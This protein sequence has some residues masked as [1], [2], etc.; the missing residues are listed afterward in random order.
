[1]AKV[2]RI[3]LAVSVLVIALAAPTSA[4]RAGDSATR[5]GRLE[6]APAARESLAGLTNVASTARRLGVG[7][8]TLAIGAALPKAE[9]TTT[10]TST[11]VPT[12]A[13]QQPST[14]APTTAVATVPSTTTTTRPLRVASLV[15]TGDIL[16]HGPV[17]QAAR[18][19]DG[20]DFLPMFSEVRHIIEAADVAICHMETPVSETN[21]NLG[22]FPLFNAP[23]AIVHAI[24]DAGYDGCSTASNHSYDQR[25]A[26]IDATIAAFESVGL[27]QAGMAR[28]EGED[29]TPVIYDAGGMKVAHIAATYWLNGFS[30]PDGEGY[31][32]DLIEPDE[33]LAEAGI[34]R[35]A[36]AEFVVVSLHWGAEYVA[37]PTADQVAWL[38]AILPSPHVD[39]V[40]GHHAHVV[41][42][43]DRL[44]EEWVVFG[45]GNFLTGQSGSCCPA[46][47]QDGVIV[48]VELAE[49]SPGVVDVAAIRYTPTYVRRPDYAIVPVAE[50][51]ARD[52]LDPGMRGLLERSLARTQAVIDSRLG[53]GAIEASVPEVDG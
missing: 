37:E 25:G 44:G 5:L 13:P 3:A 35:A 49:V 6:L 32:V 19:A 29:L 23:V 33:I 16:T 8:D 51:L 26:G 28:S 46:A 17:V 7:G 48:E 36:G 20:L 2:T 15:F 39:L 43:I 45:A 50:W 38:E 10:T 40:I 12:P 53:S 47:T 22:S 21:T 14:E 41:Q 24:A 52:D 9:P 1:M 34:A 11:T 27:R 18:T 42:P 31:L 4:P 30:L